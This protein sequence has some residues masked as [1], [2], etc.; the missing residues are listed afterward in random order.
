MSTESLFFMILVI[1][2]VW[3]GLAASIIALVRRSEA[4]DMPDGGDDTQVPDGA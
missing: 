4:V 2:V 1:V 3:G